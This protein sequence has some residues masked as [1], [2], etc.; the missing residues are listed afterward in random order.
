MGFALAE[1]A[2]RLGAA[3]TLITGP[4]HLGDAG[5]RESH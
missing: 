1:V 5:W 2:N 3:V 4:V